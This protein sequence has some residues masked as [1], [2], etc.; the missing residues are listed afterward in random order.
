LKSHGIRTSTLFDKEQKSS[1]YSNSDDDIPKT[2]IDRSKKVVI[3]ITKNLIEQINVTSDNNSYK[4]MFEYVCKNMKLM[5]PIVLEEEMR[6]QS[7]WTGILGNV[8]GNSLYYDLSPSVVGKMRE[9]IIQMLVE[10]I[11]EEDVTIIMEQP[12]IQQP[13]SSSSFEGSTIFP[14]KSSHVPV[15]VLKGHS[16]YVNSVSFSPDGKTIVSGSRD[17]TIRIWHVTL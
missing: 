17:K 8:L 12:T 4:R 15:E 10:V 13:L 14:P 11:R 2:R 9:R 7:K 5:I 6:D 16:G 1:G 3:F